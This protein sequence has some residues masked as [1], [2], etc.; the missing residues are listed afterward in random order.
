MVLETTGRMRSQEQ[1]GEAYLPGVFYT[2][3][4]HSAMLSIL[5]TPAPH[6]VSVSV[7]LVT[8]CVPKSTVKYTRFR[9][10]KSSSKSIKATK[11]KSQQL[12]DTWN[13][14]M[15]ILLGEKVLTALL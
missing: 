8:G 14:F 5:F 11:I 9:E 10:G 3:R 15:L 7:V 1:C 6:S 2:L 13:I 4:P 12:R